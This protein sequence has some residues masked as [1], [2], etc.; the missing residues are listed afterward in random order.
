MLATTARP[1]VLSS[2]AAARHPSSP[3]L[4]SLSTPLRSMS[5][6]RAATRRRSAT[7]S[8]TSHRVSASATV[9]DDVQGAMLDKPSVA[10]KNW[11]RVAAVAATVAAASRGTSYLPATGAAFVHLLAYSTWL[12]AIVWTTFV[13]GIVMF[14]NLPRQMFGRVQSKLFPIYFGL[15]SACSAVQLG[16][17]LFGAAAVPQKQLVLLGLGLASSLLS[18]LVV[19]PLCTRIMFQRYDLENAAE[20]DEGTIKALA[21]QFGKWHGISSLINLATLV[22]AVGHGYWLAGRLL[23]GGLLA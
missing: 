9:N 23:A 15:S 6:S 5:S 17:L 2:Q 3:A 20:R 12:G 22:V 13:A 7:A 8:P 11:A 21:K 19:E 4:K 14:K 10:N 18:F 16:V 1:L